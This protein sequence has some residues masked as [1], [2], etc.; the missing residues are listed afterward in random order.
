[1]LKFEYQ[2]LKECC[3]VYAIWNKVNDKLCI[4]SSLKC[5]TR[6]RD[7]KRQLK[8]NKH[9]NPYLQ[10]SWNK[11]GESAF[12]FILLD[13]VDAEDKL[14][15]IEQH[16][17]DNLRAS[18]SGFGYNCANPVKQRVVSA[19]MSS[20][21]KE[22]WAGL[23]AQEK[24]Q[25]TEH[26]STPEFQAKANEGKKS[27]EWRLKQR[28]ASKAQ[29]Q[30]PKYDKVREELHQRVKGFHTDPVILEKISKKAKVRWQDPGYR[31]RGIKQL[32][33]ARKKAA[34]TLLSDPVKHQA[35]LDLLASQTTKAA[36]AIKARWQD[37]EFRARRIAQMK[38]PRKRKPE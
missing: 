1:M 15:E 9:Y 3:G 38:L 30:W 2:A 34:E 14:L 23:S 6:C 13:E 22:Y 21:H 4:G 31:D 35:R 17:I 7:H 18:E 20:A 8:A 36:A 11:H 29:W 19:R 33:E 28:E 10:S 16:W 5:K 27:P 32:N 24:G 12:E 25:R 26:I 37:P